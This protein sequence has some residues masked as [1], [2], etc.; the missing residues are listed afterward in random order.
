MYICDIFSMLVSNMLALFILVVVRLVSCICLFVLELIIRIVC[1]L[2]IGR[3]GLTSQSTR[4]CYQFCEQS[5][6][7]VPKTEETIFCPFMNFFAN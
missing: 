2:V 5:R 7:V 3:L 6:R 4:N 1:E